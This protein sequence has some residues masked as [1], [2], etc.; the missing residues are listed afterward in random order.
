MGALREWGHRATYRVAQGAAVVVVGIFAALAVIVSLFAA[1]GIPLAIGFLFVAA[2][3]WLWLHLMAELQE[4]PGGEWVTVT[5]CT[6]CDRPISPDAIYPLCPRCEG[7]CR[8]HAEY[9]RNAR[10]FPDP[11]RRERWAD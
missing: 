11:E 4:G 6:L 10:E 5:E 9:D 7:S 1:F 2:A 3:R 8:A